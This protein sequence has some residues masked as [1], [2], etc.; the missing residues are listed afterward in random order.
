MLVSSV[1]QNNTDCV[2]VAKLANTVYVTNTSLQ[3]PR[4]YIPLEKEIWERF[5]LDLKADKDFILSLKQILREA[6]KKRNLSMFAQFISASQD[7]RPQGFITKL[8][9]LDKQVEFTT[10]EIDKFVEGVCNNEFE[11]DAL[12]ETSSVEYKIKAA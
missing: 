11:F 7:D 12:P 8:T 5:L 6:Q 4:N 1:C 3:A 10:S 9:Y 2:G